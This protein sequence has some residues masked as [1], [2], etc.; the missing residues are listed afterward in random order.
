MTVTFMP[1]A[2]VKPV[3]LMIV[4]WCSSTLSTKPRSSRTLMLKVP[5]TEMIRPWI[6]SSRL[7]CAY[8]GMSCADAIVG[9]ISPATASAVAANRGAKLFRLIIVCFLFPCRG[10]SFR[11][12]NEGT[13]RHVLGTLP[14]RTLLI[15]F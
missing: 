11:T 7:G 15:V 13:G 2:N 8:D 1:E 5:L 4:P 9:S 10:N 3:G 14:R 12:E 6:V